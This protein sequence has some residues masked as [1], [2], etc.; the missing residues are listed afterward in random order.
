[1]N[2]SFIDEYLEDYKVLKK[3]GWD[4]IFEE[5]I[6]MMHDFHYNNCKIY[7]GISQKLFGVDKDRDDQE[8]ANLAYL[9]TTIFK[10]NLIHTCKKED[11]IHIMNS[12]GTSGNLKSFDKINA[13]H[14]K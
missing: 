11:I 4:K 14:Q 12:S 9:P 3:E 5:H 6:Q 7:K 13:R 8:I 1:M 2:T 10:E